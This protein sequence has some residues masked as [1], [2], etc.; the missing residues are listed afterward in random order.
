[1]QVN[2]IISSTAT[3]GKKINTTVSYLRQSQKSQAAA[4]A[5]AL[6]ALTT[7]SYQS[8]QV[9][10]INVDITGGKPEPTLTISSWSGT[11]G[12][13]YADVNYSGDGQLY[14]KCNAPAFIT[15]YTSSRRIDVQTNGT[16]SGTIYATETDNYAS[17]TLDFSRS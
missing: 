4:L 17:K 15:E 7:N 14:V 12:G 3:N 2:A 13:Y 9:N 16:F 11:S 6:N 5:Q 1:M 10:E 8:V